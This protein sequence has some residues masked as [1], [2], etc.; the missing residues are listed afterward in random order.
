MTDPHGKHA[1]EVN[2][3][4]HHEES[5]VN[6]RALLWFVVAFVVVMVLI[7]AASKV[8]FDIFKKMEVRKDL[9]PVTRV[10]TT[11]DRTPPE[12]RLQDNPARGMTVF[13]DAEQKLL[14]STQVIDRT[15]GQ[16]R[17]PIDRALVLTA[18]RQATGA[19]ASLP[20]GS[21]PPVPATAT[22]TTTALDSQAGPASGR[23]LP[24]PQSTTTKSPASPQR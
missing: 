3:E 23:E 19:Q 12:P 2:A 15:T 17:I 10:A 11:G 9:L 4:V 21:E 5:D 16:I 8:T 20:A 13:A 22:Q 24:P 1:E 7:F 18:Q 6:V 14:G